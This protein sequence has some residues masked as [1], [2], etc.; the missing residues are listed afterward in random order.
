[1]PPATGPGAWFPAGI[2]PSGDFLPAN[3]GLVRGVAPQCS[4]LAPGMHVSSFITT[5]QSPPP[6]NTKNRGNQRPAL[7]C[8]TRGRGLV[9]RPAQQSPWLPLGPGPDGGGRVR[10]PHSAPCRPRCPGTRVLV[11][12]SPQFRGRVA[13]LCGDFDRDASND[14]RSRQGVL[15]PTAELAAHSW[16][17][18]PLCP[19]PGDLPHPCT[20]STGRTGGREWGGSCGK[21]GV[22]LLPGAVSAGEH[23]PGWL[24]SRPLR[25]AAAVAL[26]LVPPRGAP[27]AAL[28]VVPVRRLRVRGWAWRRR[29]GRVRAGAGAAGADRSLPPTAVI[30][31]ATVSVSAR[32]LPPTR[33]SVPGTGSACA[34]AA[35][36]SAVSVRR[37]RPLRP[38]PSALGR[39]RPAGRP[40]E[41]ARCEQ[42]WEGLRQESPSRALTSRG[43]T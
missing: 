7:G 12:L 41:P 4:P 29:D 3:L 21:L 2:W 16:R 19:E 26:R 35:R 22:W 25:G 11:R 10:P 13:G 17:L 37:P 43:V 8:G 15:E 30:R 36:T 20:V 38:S 6:P 14:L 27:A 39:P 32:L 40:A 18:S 34:G 23:P 5:N 1:M 24:G 28:R 31:G 9:R 33:T 42:P